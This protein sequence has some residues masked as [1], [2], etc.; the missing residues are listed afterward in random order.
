MKKSKKM[1]LDKV[2]SLNINY[3][4]QTVLGDR[5]TSDVSKWIKKEKEKQRYLRV[6]E[7]LTLKAF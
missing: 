5:D 7:E 1:S 6:V 2:A 3:V 4:D